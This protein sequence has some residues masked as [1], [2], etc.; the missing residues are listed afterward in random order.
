[1]PDNA[2]HCISTRDT[3]SEAPQAAHAELIEQ[4]KP[5]MKTLLTFV[6]FHDP[7]YKSPLEGEELKGP[8]LYLLELRRFERICLFATPNLVDRTRETAAA[9]K[10]G[11]PQTVVETRHLAIDDPTDYGQIFAALRKDFAVIDSEI[12]DAGYYIATASGTPQM[13]AV[14][15][16]LAACGEI[17]ARILQA[18]PPQFVTAQKQAVDEIDPLAP[19]FPRVRAR[20]SYEEPEEH[21]L[22]DAAQVIEDLGIVGRHPL[23]EKALDRAA[24][25]AESE[26]PVLIQGDTGTGKELVARLIHRLSGRPAHKFVAFNCAAIPRELAESTLFGHTRGAFTGATSDQV[27]KFVQADGGTLFLDEIGQMPP[28]VQAKLLRVLEDGKVEPVGSSRAQQVDV[29]IIAA[30]NRDLNEAVKA[31]EFRGDLYY[32]IEVGLINLPP[33]KERRSDIPLLALNAIDN[34]NKKPRK[35]ISI[36]QEAIRELTRHNWPGNVRQLLNLLERSAAFNRRDMLDKED[37]SFSE[38]RSEEDFLDSLPEPEE[39]FVMEEILDRIKSHLVHAAMKSSDGNQSAA[40]RKLAMTPQ[41]VHNFLKREAI[42]HDS[43]D[44]SNQ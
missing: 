12:T 19:G 11:Y 34:I 29:R 3:N 36:S 38:N 16:M 43:I 28:Q 7:Y 22:P 33:L 2:L 1:M 42:Y 27:G 25:I 8:I 5:R 17:P 13:T 20:P 44:E 23:F 41:G 40:A 15:L 14:W 9:V 18:R 10:A 24:M 37:L 21:A 30:S 35:R 26:Y 6:G 31:D 4:K 32:R 39:G